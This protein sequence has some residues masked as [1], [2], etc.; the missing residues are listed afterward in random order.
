MIVRT[1]TPEAVFRMPQC[2]AFQRLNDNIR[3]R[4]FEFSDKIEPDIERACDNTLWDSNNTFHKV[5][6]IVENLVWTSRAANTDRFH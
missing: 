1:T 2:I 5:T 3:C 4:Q 6:S